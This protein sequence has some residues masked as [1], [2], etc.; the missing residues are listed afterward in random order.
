[1]RKMR[2]K[3]NISREIV[4]AVNSILI[5]ITGIMGAVHTTTEISVEIDTETTIER[6]TIEISIE[7]N[8][9]EETIVLPLREHTAAEKGDYTAELNNAI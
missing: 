9:E 2:R 1:M 5:D 3:G 4:S 8:T 6:T 7:T